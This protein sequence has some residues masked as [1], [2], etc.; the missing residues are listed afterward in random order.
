VQIAE[1]QCKSPIA[2]SARGQVI[3][4]GAIFPPIEVTRY[5]LTREPAGTAQ[6]AG[7]MHRFLR[8]ASNIRCIFAHDFMLGPLRLIF[9]ALLRTAPVYYM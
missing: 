9:T 1:L 6:G 4:P 7:H 3:L 5:Q 2:C 8:I